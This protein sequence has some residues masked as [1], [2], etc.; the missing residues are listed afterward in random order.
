MKSACLAIVALGALLL[1]WALPRL[2]H[3]RSLA[4][5]FPAASA[6]RGRFADFE[7]AFGTDDTLLVTVRDDD[8][9]PILRP[10]ALRWLD[11]LHEAVAGDPA[12]AAATSLANLDELVVDELPVAG[13]VPLP[14][15]PLVPRDRDA[16]TAAR[17]EELRRHPLL[18]EGLLSDDGKT[19]ACWLLLAPG[20]R[21]APD[22][23]AQ[24]E[25]LAAKVPEP[26]ADEGALHVAITGFPLLQSATLEL[27]ARDGMRLLC[28]ALA[29]V[30]LLAVAGGVKW[31]TGAAWLA[32]WIA[33][34][35]ILA[36][37][38]VV[39][40][41]PLHLFSPTLLPLLLVTSG[42]GFVH[43]ARA[44]A[45]G[46]GEARRRAVKVTALTNG[47]TALGFA[48]L[49]FSPLEPLARLGTEMA[50]GTLLSSGATLLF[51]VAWTTRATSAEAAAG[52]AAPSGGRGA[53]WSR[54]TR[55]PRWIVAA[56]ALLCVPWPLLA[57]RGATASGSF[58]DALPQDH[59]RVVA[60]RGADA[61]IGA[62]DAFEVIVALEP[63]RAAAQLRDPA[64][65]ADLALFHDELL[66]AAGGDLARVLS[67]ATLL[68]Y[69]ESVVA[70][71]LAQGRAAKGPEVARDPAALARAFTVAY[72]LTPWLSHDA[73]TSPAIAALQ[74]ALRERLSALVTQ[75]G[76]RLRFGGRLRERPA[77]A[78]VALAE[79]LRGG[80]F[81][82]WRERLGAASIDCTGYALL[83]AETAVATRTTQT[84]SLLAGGA[85]LAALLLLALRDVRLGLLAIATNALAI[86]GVLALAAWSGVAL[87][88]FATVLLAAL[89]G[90]TV[91]NTLHLLL[92]WQAARRD[93][94]SDAAE[95][96]VREAG[97]SMVLAS[98]SLAAGFALFA[99]SELPVW[100]LFA[101]GACCG[102]ALALF[103]DLVALPTLL[104]RR[105]AR[106]R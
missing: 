88:L 64:F 9:Q 99:W 103:F 54:C 1:G 92:A 67:P 15:R 75:D 73:A 27:L 25:A 47:T 74:A 90:S 105:D 51:E 106:G 10:G 72:V 7:A 93:G 29:L 6:A 17:A 38:H 8:P 91:D 28:G 89:L 63:S 79:R 95:R 21:H 12:L 100:R 104:A 11:R 45:Q 40:G 78:V 5:L 61:A 62:Q 69:V 85:T 39:A 82:R 50:V 43:V 76:T 84:R 23:L 37:W 44:F 3:D 14:P 83:V 41:R 26:R 4:Q 87:D 98:A 65:L 19:A 13:L 56:V 80:L 2:E 66:A 34:A 52:S 18:R 22:Y 35:G 94:V 32:S 55:A 71:A 31:R 96:A 77:D 30:A 48:T 33:V 68:R 101:L 97:P 81:A 53:G 60:T 86:G 49:C 59:P 24:V 102:L 46:D 70:T 58:L 42:S 16:V 20:L 57:G 36:A